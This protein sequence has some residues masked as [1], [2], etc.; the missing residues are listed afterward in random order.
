MF[1]GPIDGDALV[2]LF[3]GYD[4]RFKIKQYRHEPAKN[5]FLWLQDNFYPAVDTR[6]YH[7]IGRRNV[8]SYVNCMI[9]STSVDFLLINSGGGT[10]TSYDYII[11]CPKVILSPFTNFSSTEINDK[12][13]FDVRT[14][15]YV[16]EDLHSIV[17]Y[18]MS[19]IHFLFSEF[20]LTASDAKFTY[21]SHQK[22]MIMQLQWENNRFQIDMH[23]FGVN[24]TAMRLFNKRNDMIIPR[25]SENH[26]PDTPIAFEAIA[27]CPQTSYTNLADGGFDRC[28]GDIRAFYAT[29]NYLLTIQFNTTEHHSF[30]VGTNQ[31]DLIRFDDHIRFAAGAGGHD[32]YYVHEGVDAL[33]MNEAEDNALDYVVMPASVPRIFSRISDSLLV[34]NVECREFFVATRHQHLIFVDNET[35]QFFPLEL[36]YEMTPFIQATHQRNAFVLDETFDHDYIIIHDGQGGAA[37]E[38]YRRKDDLVILRASDDA[39]TSFVLTIAK[40]YADIEKWSNVTWMMYHDN[41]TLNVRYDFIFDQS[42][43]IDYQTKLDQDF[44]DIFIEYLFSSSTSGTIRSPATPDRISVLHIDRA[45]SSQNIRI[46]QR[47]NRHL[48]LS[49][50]VSHQTLEIQDWATPSKR[51]SIIELSM[52]SEHLELVSIR[53][54]SRFRLNQAA[55][56]EALLRLAGESKQLLQ[57][58]TSLNL[59]GI[60]C[61]ISVARLDAGAVDTYS[62]LGF[63]TLDDQ[64]RFVNKYCVSPG[65][66]T[67]STLN[68]SRAAL[69]FLQ[70]AVVPRHANDSHNNCDEFFA[71]VYQHQI[72]VDPDLLD[73]RLLAAVNYASTFHDLIRYGANP[74]ARSDDSLARSVLHMAALAANLKTIKYIVS[75][76]LVDI[77][78]ADAQGDTAL[79]YIFDRIHSSCSA[80]QSLNVRCFHNRKVH[81]LLEIASYLLSEMG[82]VNDRDRTRRIVNFIRRHASEYKDIRDFAD[83]GM[84]NN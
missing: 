25:V 68:Q 77:N 18:D 83:S 45:I 24:T 74:Q 14:N 28:I 11:D 4:G 36:T 51:I 33:I 1:A 16:G 56:M 79:Q 21:D 15:G 64:V 5:W 65:S 41:G 34:S 17:Q 9:D 78:V 35:N 31:S 60:K 54:L 22:L 29:S 48:V 84:R 59:V 66:N 12:V 32:I 72:V 76:R 67:F 63:D 53:G 3:T 20:K 57:A 82:T 8:K 55:E 58:F 27:M 47:D 37:Y 42:N 26:T 38:K 46:S 2:F 69:K 23:G 73:A 6:T 62:C 52:S 75:H 70:N 30:A 81:N 71:S 50:S 19:T 61:I 80:G 7:Y 44:H 10:K 39:G 49:D 40:F 43:I 13:V